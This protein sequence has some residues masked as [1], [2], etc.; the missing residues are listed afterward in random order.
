MRSTVY[1]LV[2][3]AVLVGV[4]P[5]ALAAEPIPLINAHAHNDYLHERP[6][7]DALDH[8][9]CSIEADVWLIDGAMLV[10]HKRSEVDPAR[11]LQR[12]YL[13]PLRERVKRNG[14]AVYPGGPEIILLI[15]IKGNGHT[16]YPVLRET[17]RQYADILTTFTDDKVEV[18]AVRAIVSGSRPLEMMRAFD[19][20]YAAYDGRLTDLDSDLSAEMMPLISNSWRLA[21]KWNGEGPMPEEESAKLVDFVSEAH[22]KSR[23]IRFWDTP[24]NETIWQELREA[25]VDLISADDLGRLRAFLSRSF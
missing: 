8:G 4:L 22:A 11:T 14:G 2:L 5:A 19:T 23:K 9:F 21:F 7:R 3:L 6:L 10:A 20:H 16:A 17:L 15:D 24:E 18:R 25:G 12:L 1:H 13:D